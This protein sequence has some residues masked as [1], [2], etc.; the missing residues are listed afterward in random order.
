MFRNPAFR[1]RT[2]LVSFLMFAQ[3]C[4]GINGISSYFV[5]IFTGLGYSGVKPLIMSG[6][7]SIV[8]TICVF[9]ACY[10]VDSFGRRSMFLTGFPV[11]AV[12][13]L[14][15]G[16]VQWKYEGTDNKACLNAAIA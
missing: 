15:E 16:L 13:L 6:I 4:S 7:Y 2:L 5:P 8:G 11:L 12:I 3:Q 14:V 9:T 10:T 1:K